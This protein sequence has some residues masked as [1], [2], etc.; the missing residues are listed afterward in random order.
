MSTT[1]I[2]NITEMEAAQSQP[3]LIV[4]G[5]VRRLEA[6][7]QLVVIDQDQATPPGSPSDGDRHIVGPGATGDWAGH[8][9]DVALAIGG[10]WV[11]FAPQV[12]WLA[13]VTDDAGYYRF[14]GGS[15][16]GWVLFSGGGGGGGS[17]G[18]PVDATAGA[19]ENNWNPTGWAGG[20]GV[21]QLRITPAGGGSTI[22]GLDSSGVQ[23][24]DERTL[25][26]ESAV[27]TITLPN[28]AG[29]SS[30]GNRFFGPGGADVALE[31]RG[32]F[33]IIFH[34]ALGGWRFA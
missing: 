27:D 13:W 21:S 1:P 3:H 17:T 34:A 22:T 5:A 24:G 32:G 33:R 25:Q 4:N 10:G 28:N 19:N 15:P 29:G 16:G 2:L 7:G 26:N 6:V 23:D 18:T 20:D 12:G 30:A 9:S 31:P 14:G 11:F 8:D